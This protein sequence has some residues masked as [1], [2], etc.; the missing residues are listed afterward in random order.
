MDNEKRRAY[1]IFQAM[2][3]NNK[4]EE[5][6]L[7]CACDWVHR[8]L[9]AG[10]YSCQSLRNKSHR[11]IILSIKTLHVCFVVMGHR[12]NVKFCFQFRKTSTETH[13]MLK[14]VYGN[15]ALPHMHVFE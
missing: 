3:P 9:V 8:T 11:S 15:E 7:L 2:T 13:E 12:M 10:L 1:R 14:I 4:V 5:L 6:M